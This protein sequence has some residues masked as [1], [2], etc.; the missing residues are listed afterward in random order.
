MRHTCSLSIA[1]LSLL[2]PAAGKLDAARRPRYGGTLRVD[3]RA[4]VQSLDPGDWPSDTLDASAKQKLTTQVFETLVRLDERGNLK[5]LLA[6]S[7]THE[8]ARKRWIFTLRRNVLLH[9]GEPWN[10]PGGVVTVP[11]DRPLEDI[12]RNLARP[13]NAVV[14]RSS[15]VLLGTGPFH[16]ARFEPGK[17]LTLEANEQ[18]WGGRPF[19]DSVQIHMGQTLRDQGLRFDLGKTDVAQI[20]MPEAQRLRQRGAKVAVSA[21]AEILALQVTNGAIPDAVRERLALAVDRSAIHQVLLRR[22]G[23]V[24][25]ALLPQ[26]LS[27]Y[28]FLFPGSYQAGRL[29]S[30]AI[31]KFSYDRDDPLVRAI[32]ERIALNA[33]EAGIMLRAGSP[34]DVRLLRLCVT[35]P[36]PALAI[37][38]L[39]AQLEPAGAGAGKGYEKEKTLLDAHRVI[40][41][42]H[43]PL[44]YRLNERVHNWLGARWVPANQWD[45]ANVWVEESR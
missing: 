12:L 44:A 10:P 45:F 11:D 41:L 19:L 26:W 28:A 18:Y 30:Q 8:P 5:P 7:W 34:P 4:A 25:G 38:D 20:P 36:D 16:I 23:E 13:R 9:N 35:L 37:D 3:I 42:F 39:S 29:S 40:P 22:Q 32:G 15:D 6:V 24:S 2:L 43:L 27:G 14:V 33:A 31:L 21:P 1:A 17:M